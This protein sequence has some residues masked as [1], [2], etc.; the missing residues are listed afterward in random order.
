MSDTAGESFITP[1]E[2]QKRWN[3]K[4][5]KTVYR[6]LRIHHK[7]LQPTLIGRQHRI[8]STNLK[9]FEQESIIYKENGK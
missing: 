8:C 7:V 5:I 9:K 3:L 1:Q 2:L 6:V 4:T